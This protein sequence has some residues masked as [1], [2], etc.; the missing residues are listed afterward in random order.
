MR[1]GLTR[2]ILASVVAKAGLEL[3]ILCLRLVVY[4]VKSIMLNSV[5]LL[6]RLIKLPRLALNVLCFS[7]SLLCDWAMGPVFTGYI[8]RTL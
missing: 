8:G 5:L 3:L 1:Q 6:D 4:D 2:L 7:L